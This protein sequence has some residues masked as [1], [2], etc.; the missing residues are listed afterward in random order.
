MS[1]QSEQTGSK[2]EFLSRYTDLPATIHL[3]ETK[4]I[5]LLNPETWDDRNDAFILN[6]Y[7]RQKEATSVLALCFSKTRDKYHH[8]KVFAGGVGG[9]RIDFDK[10]LLLKD[11]K[12]DTKFKSGEVIYKNIKEVKQS[13]HPTREL[14]FLKRIQ[15]EDDQEYRIIFIDKHKDV[16]YKQVNFSLN[17]IRRITLSP[18]MPKTIVQSVKKVLKKI[19]GC[20]GMEIYHST[21]IN[22]EV[23]KKA[24]S[25]DRSG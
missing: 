14:P 15:F 13:E 19:D 16:E 5:T 6:Q 23:W 10:E 20:Q 21:L 24:G 17:C 9:V 4:S 22:N 11:M 2:S 25:A 3:L 7:K 8:W 18:W 12:S 1:N